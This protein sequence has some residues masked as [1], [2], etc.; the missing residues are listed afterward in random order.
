[1]QYGS[2]AHLRRSSS[3]ANES[4]NP[5]FRFGMWYGVFSSMVQIP[6]FAGHVLYGFIQSNPMLEMSARVAESPRT[7]LQMPQSEYLILYTALV[8]DLLMES[9]RA[10]SRG[11]PRSEPHDAFWSLLCDR[12]PRDQSIGHL[13]GGF[14]Q[15]NLTMRMQIR[16]L[17]RRNRPPL[18]LLQLLPASRIASGDASDGG[19]GHGSRLEAFV[20]AQYFVIVN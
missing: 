3:G 4:P 5:R 2:L 14:E 20:V 10:L 9:P 7:G 19:G 1:M 17:R 15:L 8:G 12:R 11:A 18:R 16:R 6:F 13:D